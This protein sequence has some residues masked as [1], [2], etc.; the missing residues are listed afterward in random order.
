MTDD[1]TGS[2]YFLVP[3]G[4]TII[5]IILQDNEGIVLAVPDGVFVILKG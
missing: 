2:F 4:K 1:P 3:I 5:I